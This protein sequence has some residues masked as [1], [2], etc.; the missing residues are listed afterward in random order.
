MLNLLIQFLTCLRPKIF[1]WKTAFHENTSRILEEWKLFQELFLIF[2]LLHHIIENWSRPNHWITA[3]SCFHQTEF[4][5]REILDL[6]L[7]EEL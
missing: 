1:S 3:L 2:P 4:T 7:S 6:L 5:W